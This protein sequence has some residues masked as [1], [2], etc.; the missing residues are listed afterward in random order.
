[1]SDQLEALRK[2]REALN[3]WLHMHA[4]DMCDEAGVADANAKIR[5]AGG[6]LGF[7]T[8]AIDSLTK[9]IGDDVR[10]PKDVAL[11]SAALKIFIAA[12]QSLPSPA[13]PEDANG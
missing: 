7:I 4:G 8:S 1:M 11:Q 13:A 2:A 5:E 6:T 3:V 9:A 12:R 10:K